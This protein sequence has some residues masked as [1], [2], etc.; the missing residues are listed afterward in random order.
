M[1][2][3]KVFRSRFISVCI[4]ILLVL[5]SLVVGLLV[6]EGIGNAYGWALVN[7][8]GR[9]HSAPYEMLDPQDI[10]NWILRPG[11]QIT[12]SE[13]MEVWKQNMVAVAIATKVVQKYGS[14]PDDVFFQINEFGFKG[15]DI[16]KTK[17]P[18][19]IRIMTIGDS[20]TF[21]HHYDWSSYSRTLER[22]LQNQGNQV[23]VINA[24]VEG[25]AT[26]NVLSRLDYF[27]SFQPDIAIIYLG[28]NDLYTEPLGVKRLWSYRAFNYFIGRSLQATV[29]REGMVYYTDHYY[30]SSTREAHRYD[31]NYQPTFLPQVR[32]IVSQLSENG[33]KPVVVTLPMAFSIDNPPSEETLKMCHLPVDVKNAYVLAVM[34]DKYNNALRLLAS[35][36]NIPLIDLEEWAETE[37]VPPESWFFDSVHLW[38]EG[39]MAIGDHIGERLISLGLLK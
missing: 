16:G 15:P 34:V 23:E 36:E 25:Y 22:Y 35:E 28:W 24:G 19:T 27:M 33:V 7:R 29:V 8:T 39:Q 17:E 37:L 38:S 11:Y 2:R 20:C 13:F 21:G 31:S 30:D 32:Q 6:V 5:A 1:K 3:R 14:S 18:D 12:L 9:G 4:S 10:N 26:W